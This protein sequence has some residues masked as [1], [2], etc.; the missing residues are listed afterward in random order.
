MKTDQK[1]LSY[2]QIAQKTKQLHA[3]AKTIVFTSGCYDILHLG[4]VIHF[5][6]CQ[7]L[8]DCLIVSIGND[9]TVHNLKGPDRPIH[10]ERFRARMVAALAVVDYVVISQESGNMDHDQLVTLTKPDIY[11]VPKTDTMLAPKTALI[12]SVGGKL[13]ACSRHAPNHHKEGISTTQIANR[14]T[15]EII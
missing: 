6:Y 5:N 3:K 12:N 13:V 7:S 11:V 1:I 15:R 8:G 2:R 10:N 9:Q 4:H 14:I